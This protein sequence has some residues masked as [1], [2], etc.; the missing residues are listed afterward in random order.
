MSVDTMSSPGKKVG[1]A[2]TI[3]LWVV[4]G[5]LA[6]LFVLA[7]SMKFANAEQAG[8]RFA[9][10]G[11]PDW[12]RV[13]IGAVEIGAGLALLIPRTTFYAA[14]ALGVVM[15]GAVFTHLRQGEIPQSAVPLVLLVVLALVGYARRPRTAS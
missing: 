4:G 1:K 15:A 2:K 10:Y 3:A 13:L 5:L 9:G 12:F 11:Y 8:E 6:A 14:A 7:G